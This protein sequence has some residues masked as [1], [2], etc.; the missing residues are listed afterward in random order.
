MNVHTFLLSHIHGL[1]CSY[2]AFVYMSLPYD[3]VILYVILMR[4]RLKETCIRNLCLQ[5]PLKMESMHD[6]CFYN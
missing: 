2:S 1:E 5:N 6:H 3:F 4:L